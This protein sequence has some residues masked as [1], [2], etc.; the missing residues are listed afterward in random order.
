MNDP[1]QAT[2]LVGLQALPVPPTCGSRRTNLLRPPNCPL[3]SGP[4]RP[5]AWSALTRYTGRTLRTI[6][7]R[8]EHS[9]NLLDRDAIHFRD[10]R[11]QCQEQRLSTK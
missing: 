6:S 3:A 2:V 10:S 8:R 5:R 1:C 7:T 11:N 4:V 9:L